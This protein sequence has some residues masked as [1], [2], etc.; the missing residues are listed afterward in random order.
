MKN[1]LNGGSS[2]NEMEKKEKVAANAIPESR[3]KTGQ[4]EK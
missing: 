1:E 4:I 3:K 2:I